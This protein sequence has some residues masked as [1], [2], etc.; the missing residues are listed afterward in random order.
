MHYRSPRRRRESDR[1]KKI[2]EDIIAENFSNL[3]RKQTSR[4]RKH[5]VP[6]RINPK[7]T[8]PKHI[9]IKIAKI[10]IKREY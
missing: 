4:S 2:F 6:D 7:K 1:D 3:E 10:N 8:T 9:V 5:R